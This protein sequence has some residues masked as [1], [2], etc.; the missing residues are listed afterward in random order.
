MIVIVF[1]MIV[2]FCNSCGTNESKN[3]PEGEVVFNDNFCVSGDA[4]LVNYGGVLDFYCSQ[5]SLL[6]QF[7][8]KVSNNRIHWDGGSGSTNA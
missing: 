5:D 2:I 6:I 3:C 1:A 7:T 4:A 8:E